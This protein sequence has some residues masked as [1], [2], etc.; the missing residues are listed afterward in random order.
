MKYEEPPLEPVEFRE[1]RHPDKQQAQGI[2]EMWCE[3][4]TLE[5]ARL[6]PMA[7]L[8]QSAKNENYEVRLIIW[9]TRE[10]PLPSSGFLDIYVQAIYLQDNWA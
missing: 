8:Q 10:L 5:E 3:V 7:K 1:L 2:I 9:E 4:L 6:R